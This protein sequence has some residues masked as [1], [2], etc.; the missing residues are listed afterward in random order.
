MTDVPPPPP[1][2]DG[3]RHVSLDYAATTPVDPEVAAAMLLWLGERF[4]NPSSVHFYGRE[5]RK[6]VE[7][8]RDE[9]AAL[10]GAGPD[11][12][13]FTGCATEANNLAILGCVRA[14]ARNR[15][16]SL[17]ASAVEHPSVA[18]PFALLALE[19]W[20]VSLLPVD[21]SGRVDLLAAERLIG[22]ETA[23]AS[24]MLANN[25]TGT[26]QPVKDIA[27]L[28]HTQGALLHVDAAQATGKISVDVNTLGADLLT[29]AGHKFYAPK[30]IGVLYVRRGTPLRPLM[31]G[32]G[33]ERGLRPGTENVPAIAG[34]GMAARLV[35]NNLAREAHRMERLRER[36]YRRLAGTIPG[37]VLNGSSGHHLPSTLNLS[38][39]G[40]A[41]RRPSG[42]S[43]R[44]L[45]LDGKRLPWRN[46][47][48]EP[49]PPG[50]GCHPSEPGPIHHSRCD[51]PCL[52]RPGRFLEE[53]DFL[54]DSVSY[55]RWYDTP[56]GRWTGEMEYRLLSRELR[57]LP[58]ESLLDAG[59]GTG[60]FSRR[61]FRDGL[62]VTGVDRNMDWLA[63]A[64]E[65]GPEGLSWIGGDLR[66]LPFRDRRFDRVVSVAALCFVGDER[67]AVR[68][69]VRVTNRRFAIGWLNRNSLLYARKGRNGGAGSWRGA[70]WHRPEEIHALF[71]GLPVEALEFHSCVFLPSGSFGARTA[72]AILPPSW[73]R[74]SLIVASG[75]RRDS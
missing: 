57:A 49:G 29:L 6:K 67:K 53:V 4:G 72:E 14:L 12:F 1:D 36:L 34:L 47:F 58:G 63:F 9:V 8:S 18:G 74:G 28:I 11:E 52:R 59:C 64:R 30:G 21:S 70:R 23:F 75:K 46:F 40:G 69:I 55:D 2:D 19:G 45:R 25:E 26:V 71:D 65:K 33:Q 27:R 41:R 43:S 24:V 50:D 10:I 73:L 39:S 22:P 48:S 5:A 38:L 60:W 32:G 17:A 54:M 13:V 68:E 3:N 20:N 15:G 56:K 51:R 62:R 31:A 37:I 61:F 7:E 42:E 44:G 16:R 66:A 35:R